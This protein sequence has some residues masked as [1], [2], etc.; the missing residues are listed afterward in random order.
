M[1]P[2]A[3]RA[4]RRTSTAVLVGAIAVAVIAA[5]A[6]Q[7]ARQTEGPPLVQE[8]PSRIPAVGVNI[9]DQVVLSPPSNTTGAM[10]DLEALYAARRSAKAE[11]FP[12]AAV[13]AVVT[14]PGTI[15]PPDSPVPFRTIQDRLSWVITVTSSQPQRVGSGQGFLASHYSVIIDAYTGEFLL[16]FYTA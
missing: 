3:E 16:G 9:N 14:V 15:P 2:R 11:D 13:L 4:P 12:P 5:F 8:V 10:S 6:L 1:P 7:G